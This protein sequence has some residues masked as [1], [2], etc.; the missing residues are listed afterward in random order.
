MEDITRTISVRMIRDP[1]GTIGSGNLRYRPLWT[2]VSGAQLFDRIYR[3]EFV[4]A[5]NEEINGIASMFLE[6]PEEILVEQ[7]WN[8]MEYTFHTR[9][10][11]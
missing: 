5:A 10:I 2:E 3:G 8:G 7:K 1:D 11:W 6:V 9:P 4:R